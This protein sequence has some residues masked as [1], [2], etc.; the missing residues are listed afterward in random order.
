MVNRL[1]AINVKILLNTI[2]M[3]FVQMRLYF[4]RLPINLILAGLSLG[5]FVIIYEK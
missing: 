5:L 3:H 2:D 4:K 1:L